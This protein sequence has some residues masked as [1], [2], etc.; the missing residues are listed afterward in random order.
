MGDRFFP[1]RHGNITL[2]LQRPS[3]T[4]AWSLPDPGLPGMGHNGGPPLDMSG[5]GWLWR[6]AVAKA[7]A[8]PPREVALQRLRRAERLGLSYRDFTAALMDTGSSLSVAL[9][10]LH[11]LLALDQR[12]DGGFTLREDAA[13]AAHLRRFEGRLFLMLD[14]AMTGAMDA[15]ARRRLMVALGEQFGGQVEDLLVL[16]FRLTESDRARA[17]RLGRLLKTKGLLRK[18]CFLLG[19]TQSELQLAQQAGLGFFKHLPG[20]FAA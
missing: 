4:P 10:P 14:E 1:P 7:W 18:E 8:S 5:A 17:A 19:R 20:W 2:L 15:R 12:R 13:I 9:L 16:P 11:H 6:R 3:A